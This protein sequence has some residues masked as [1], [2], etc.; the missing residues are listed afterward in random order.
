MEWRRPSL[1][2]RCTI[3][4]A[5]RS[6]RTARAPIAPDCTPTTPARSPARLGLPPSAST[7][8]GL[9][10]RSVGDAACRPHAGTAWCHT[11]TAAATS[12]PAMG[13]SETSAS[14][15]ATTA[16]Y[17]LKIQCLPVSPCPACHCCPACLPFCRCL[18]LCVYPVF[19]CGVA[20]LGFR[21]SMMSLL[22]APAPSACIGTDR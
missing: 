15:F 5:H 12:T 17:A 7:S 2:H 20:P 14:L 22:V 19:C 16:T 6:L 1:C 11:Q 10:A 9:M 18:P 3:A 13:R 8:A 21:P 4:D